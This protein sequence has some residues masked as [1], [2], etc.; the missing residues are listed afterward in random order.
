MDGGEKRS[1]FLA[2]EERV[3][4]LIGKKSVRAK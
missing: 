2:S 3:V 4:F 1:V